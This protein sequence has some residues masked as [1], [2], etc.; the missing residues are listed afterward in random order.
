MWNKKVFIFTIIIGEIFSCHSFDNIIHIDATDP[1]KP[2]IAVTLN[3]DK[4]NALTNELSYETGRKVLAVHM[5]RE[6]GITKTTLSGKYQLKNNVLSFTPQ[7][8][9]GENL[10]FEIRYYLNNDTIKRNFFT[11][12]SPKPN[13][14]LPE[15]EKIFPISDEIPANILNFYIRFDQQMQDDI[16]AFQNVKIV[17]ARGKEKELVWRHKSHWLDNNKVLVLMI[18]PGRVKRGIDY[19]KEELGD[20]FT[21]GETYTLVV[22]PEIKNRFLQPLLKTYSKTFTIISYDRKIPKICFDKFQ[23]PKVNTINSLTLVFSEGMDYT[24]IHEEVTLFDSESKEK[25]SGSIIYT[26]HDSI[27]KFSP[28][29]LG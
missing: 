20:L 18:H 16:Q 6:N 25:I 24:S 2:V 23:L 29:S 3:P 12:S 19:K 7:Q 28:N 8:R 5:K 22:T 10:E 1:G 9:L 21:V 4:K 27:F 26:S 17:D 11:P 15:V 13:I 14:P